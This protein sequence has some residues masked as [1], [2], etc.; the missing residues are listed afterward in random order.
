MADKKKTVKIIRKKRDVPKEVR[1]A[2][3]GYNRI[4]R[5]ILDSLEKEPRTILEIADDTGL[6]KANVTYHLMTLMKFD[7]VEPDRMDDMDQY[8]YYRL[9]EG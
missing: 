5:S 4:K 8:Y 3:K 1:E 9:K 6:E 7:M 2:L